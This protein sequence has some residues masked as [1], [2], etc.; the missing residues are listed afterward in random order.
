MQ[1]NWTLLLP[2][3]QFIY[4]AIL[5]EGI[6]ILL[7]KANYGYK[8]KISLSLQQVKKSSKTVKER[9]ETLI[10]LYKDL[11]KSVKIV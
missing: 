4:N 6:G 1:N 10:N 5:Q 3:T 8:L 7:F 9:V 2:A 11:Q